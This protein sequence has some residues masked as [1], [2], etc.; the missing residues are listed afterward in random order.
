MKTIINII[1]SVIITFIIFV[2]KE[3]AA[4]L[5]AHYKFDTTRLQDRYFEDMEGMEQDR[6][7]ILLINQSINESMWMD[8]WIRDGLDE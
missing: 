4:A 6:S 7:I 2:K 8:E 3:H 1:L 5:L